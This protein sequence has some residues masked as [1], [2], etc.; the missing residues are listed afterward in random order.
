MEAYHSRLKA[1]QRVDSGG[2][3]SGGMTATGAFSAVAE[4]TGTSYMELAAPELKKNGASD[5]SGCH[6]FESQEEAC[7]L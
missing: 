5:I 3:E 4:K 1:L 6:E 7:P 2:G